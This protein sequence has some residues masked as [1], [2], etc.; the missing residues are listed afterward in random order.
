[1]VGKQWVLYPLSVFLVMLVAA[2]L[3]IAGVAPGQLA[4]TAPFVLAVVFIAVMWGRGPATVAA[5][6]NVIVFNYLF[7]PPAFSFSVPTTEEGLLLM[8]LLAVALVLGTLRDRVRR[9]EQ[10]VRE[11]GARE[12]L[13]KTLLDAISHD[14]KTPLTAIMGSLNI[15]LSEGQ[16]LTAG[17]RKE[18][19]AVMYDQA[20]RLD[21]LITGIL[22]MTRLEAGA[23]RLRREPTQLTDVIEIAMAHL[24][25]MSTE[26]RCRVKVPPGLPLVLIDSVLLSHALANLFDNALKF[27]PTDAPIEVEA[28][29]ADGHVLIGVADRGIGVPADELD[30]VFEKFY[31]RKQADAVQAAATGTGLGLAVAK[32]IVEAHG[33]RIWA[34]QR[35]G[36]GI[37]VRVSL[38][39]GDR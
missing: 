1:L 30:R 38:P 34:E 3:Y 35:R 32:G 21:R 39:V 14:L 36:G 12:R 31:R 17:D 4:V 5:L 7:I 27:S 33:G 24:P 9:A 29:Q 22:E 10:E 15:I 25:E 18:L 16:G 19:M 6:A 20:K 13:Q 2:V 37:V 23:I 11:F 28:R 26:R 8:S